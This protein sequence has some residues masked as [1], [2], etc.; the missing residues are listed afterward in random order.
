VWQS[1]QEVPVADNHLEL[2]WQRYREGRTSEA[3]N[4]WLEAVRLSPKDITSWQALGDLY[5]SK[6]QWEPALKAYS[7]IA[8]LNKDTPDLWTKIARAEVRMGNASGA[9]QAVEI[10]LKKNPNDVEALNILSTLYLRAEES[11]NRTEVLQ[12]LAK[13]KPD[14]VAVLTKAADA[15]MIARRYAEA[16][17]LVERIL[18]LNPQSSTA[19]S[20]RG[21]LIFNQESSP[22]SMQR[23]ITD[24]RAA[25]NA[26]PSNWVARWYLGR[27]Y[28]RQNKVKEALA[29]LEKVD[30]VHPG[31]KRYLTDLAAAYQRDGQEKRAVATNERFASEERAVHD[32]TELR[33]RLNAAPN[34]F[35]S[36]LR[37]GQLL[38]ASRKPDGALE[39]L[40][41]ALKL[42]PKDARVQQALRSLEADYKRSLDAGLQ[43]L[44][45]RKGEPALQNLSRV[46]QLKPQDPR[47]K[48]AIEELAA[49]LR[50]DFY[51]AVRQLERV[52]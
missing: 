26:Q 4:E 45:A 37:L 6:G 25:L 18:A 13:L 20:M 23:A 34:D 33:S 40:Q 28:L 21:A 16:K 48:K 39:R 14:D 38:L 3:E 24:F 51:Q 8:K 2:G 22:A 30:A 19:L 7:V 49:A 5:L 36:S 41:T 52:A 29:E 32:I 12:R 10:S 44:R 11:R 17:P 47:T 1:R 46:L 9:R 31:N 43:S 27:C 50:I 15:L 42:R 35:E